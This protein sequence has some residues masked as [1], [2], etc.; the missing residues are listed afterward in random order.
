[1]LWG[2]LIVLSH[3]IWELSAA[4]I[5]TFMGW[6]SLIKG[7]TFLVVPNFLFKLSKPILKCG[8]TVKVAMAI[9]LIMGGYLS[10]VGYFA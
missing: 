3:N 10:Y 6:A 1:M 2:L 7:A 5:I 9:W 8:T 4:G